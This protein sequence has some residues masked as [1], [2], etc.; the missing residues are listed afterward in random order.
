MMK[1]VSFQACKDGSTYANQLIIQHVNRIKD[2]NHMIILIDIEKVFNKIQHAFMIKSFEE[3]GSRR[4]VPQHKENLYRKS[5]ANA[6][7]SGEKLKLFPLNSRM[8]LRY[9]VS[10]VL[11]NIV[12][13]FLAR[14]IKQE[15]EK[16]G[17]K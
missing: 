7:L 9:P 4:N 5:I 2:K 12:I 17:Y 15:K 16:K 14:E 10:P 11:F 3:I 6:A 1:L 13:K 8:Q